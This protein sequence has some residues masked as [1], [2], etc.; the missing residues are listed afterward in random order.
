MKRFIKN[1]YKAISGYTFFCIAV[2]ALSLYFLFPKE[3]ITKRIIYELEKG[4]S[5]EIKTRDDK[6]TFPLGISFKNFEFRKKTGNISIVIG[7]LDKFSINVPVKSILSFSPVSEI[8]ANSYGGSINGII[9]LR[10]TNNITQASW[11]NVDI[12]RIEKIKDIPAEVTGIISGDMVLKLINNNVPEGQI[13][14]SLKNGKLGKIKIMGFPLPDIPVTE[15]NGTI[16]I[17]GQSLV[18][19]DTRFKNND[20]KGLIKGDIQLQTASSPGNINIAIKFA[21]GEKMKK[22]QRGIL[23]FIEKTKDKEGYYTIQIKGDLKKP[24]VSI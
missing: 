6:W 12:A 18:F 22:E 3:A 1:H 10:N 15:L 9:T 23:S 20:L 19:K 13:R 16:D 7:H 11:N 4:T 21:P 14:L 5:T 2:F 8:S 24:S 17:K